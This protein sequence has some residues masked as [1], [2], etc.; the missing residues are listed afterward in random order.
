[1]HSTQLV[2]AV[3][4]SPKFKLLQ[5]RSKDVQKW[6][7]ESHL[8]LPSWFTKREANGE[9]PR[10]QNGTRTEYDFNSVWLVRRPGWAICRPDMCFSLW[11]RF[12]G[13]CSSPFRDFSSSYCVQ[14]SPCF[15]FQFRGGWKG[16]FWCFVPC[17]FLPVSC[18]ND[19]LFK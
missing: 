3:N 7:R 17:G 8:D 11:K 13:F 18:L 4:L 14:L 9:A 5:S 2:K 6:R 19:R 1:L 12:R 15:V 16:V 10:V